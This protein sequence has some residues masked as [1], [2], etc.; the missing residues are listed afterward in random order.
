M[1]ATV[2][3]IRAFHAIECIN[4]KLPDLD[5]LQMRDLFAM[6]ALNGLMVQSKGMNSP[7][8][9]NFETIANVAYEAADAM[10]KARSKK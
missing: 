4:Q 10:L 3:V 2:E 9:W 1:E 8:F 7:E 5:K 6:N